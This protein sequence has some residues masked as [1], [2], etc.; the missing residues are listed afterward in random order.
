[1]YVRLCGRVR[2]NAASLNA[3]GTV[4]NLLEITKLRIIVKRGEVYEPVEVSAISG[5][6]IKHW[7]F[8]HF[9]RQYLQNNG[10]NL[11]EDCK[12]GIAFRTRFDMGDDEAEY[13][14]NCAGEDVHGFLMPNRQVRRESLVKFSFL[15]PVEELF[16]HPIDTI[17][18]NR[19]IIDEKG[20][21]E[22]EAGMMI[23]KR[24]YASDIYGF[25]FLADLADVGLRLYSKERK[26]V[27]DSDERKK[28][29]KSAILAFIPI[30]SGFLG[31][32]ISRSLPVFQVEE[33]LAAYSEKP[34]PLTIHGFFKNYAEE[35]L[36]TIG[37]YCK[38]S[39]SKAKISFYGIKISEELIKEYKEEIEVKPHQAWQKIF[40]EI[41]E[42]IERTKW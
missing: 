39:K 21:I 36:R 12:R 8:V 19:V 17:T 35:S 4:G 24:Q 7:H 42:E 13:I 34:L 1:M 11:C 33:L 40:G 10:N 38:I 32:N 27:C 20:K 16:E 26:P 6:T 31:A 41:I 29:A 22:G 2:V 25:S 18:H 9:I 3:Q 30:L 28:R 14:R 37:E 23:F 15:L 5:N